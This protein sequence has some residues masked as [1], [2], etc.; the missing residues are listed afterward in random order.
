MTTTNSN[1][2]LPWH[3]LLLYGLTNWGLFCA[4]AVNL[5]VGTWSA[6]NGQT[7]IAA[8]SLTAGLV[9][10]FAATV[11][12]FE[13]IKGLGVEAKTRQLDQKIEQAD[14]A[15]RRLK[16]LAEL[17]GASIIDLNSKMGRWDSVPS[18]R[19]AY[20]LAQ[21]VRAT[22]VSLGSEPSTLRQALKPWARIACLDLSRAVLAPIGKLL[23]EKA[24]LLEQ[25]RVSVRQPIDPN[26]PVFLRT[27]ASLQVC[28]AY[29][30]ERL[31]RIHQFDLDDYPENVLR[32]FDDVPFVTPEE[33][34]SAR[35]VAQSFSPAMTE[36]REK[37]QLSN[38]EP[39]L[40][41]VEAHRANQ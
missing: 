5:A 2:S 23:S 25:E 8:T 4:G 20:A 38:P 17:T 21:K 36:L 27:T 34:A 29:L 7:A 24:R 28:N 26:D 22:L 40:A 31:N 13:S 9:L 16:E 15:L 30:H 3:K 19:E 14:D 6:F 32:L 1:S 33:V 18:P 12:R 35:N 37:F 39:W 10:L 11:D 41:A